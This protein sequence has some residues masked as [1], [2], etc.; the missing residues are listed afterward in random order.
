MTYCSGSNR[1][2]GKVPD[3]SLL[4]APQPSRPYVERVRFMYAPSSVASLVVT[5]IVTSLAVA[6]IVLLSAVAAF[7]ARQLRK[8]RISRHRIRA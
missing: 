3:K 2:R 4:S 7:E 5:I 6:S 1:T 8:T